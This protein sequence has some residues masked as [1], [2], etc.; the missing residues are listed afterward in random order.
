VAILGETK[1]VQCEYHTR[2]SHTSESGLRFEGDEIPIPQGS[3]NPT[4]K[5]SKE[6]MKSYTQSVEEITSQLKDLSADSHQQAACMRPLN[7]A[8]ARDRHLRVNMVLMSPKPH[9]G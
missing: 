1:Q 9:T 7:K 4:Q 3:K 6:P 5:G 8:S 2:C